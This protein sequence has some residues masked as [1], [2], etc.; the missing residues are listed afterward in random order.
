MI[1]KSMAF[2]ILISLIL[3]MQFASSQYQAQ[4]SLGQNLQKGVAQFTDAVWS[5]ADGFVTFFFG[6]GSV[7]L[8][9]Q[10]L[11][12]L[13]IV[14]TL[15]YVLT[16]RIPLFAEKKTTIWII[17][18]SVS[19]LATRFLTRSDFVSSVLLSYSVL[20]V[21]LTSVLPLVIYFFFV[22]SFKDNP[23][24]RKILWLFFIGVFM[25]LWW[26]RSY[27][28]GWGDLEWIYFFTGIFALIF[29]LFDGTIRRALINMEMSETGFTNRA[30][31]QADILKRMD[32]TRANVS[33]G[34]LS[35][36]AGNAIIGRL[37]RQLKALAKG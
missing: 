26:Y 11:L 24:L 37:H 35:E 23:I 32:E 12:I 13:L 27:D 33:K 14:F 8:Q 4:T 7:E 17:T 34:Y 21:V 18:I 9:F 5:F 22:H 29:L 19:L 36:G 6:P 28:P 10:R 15:V 3:L 1:K 30:Q 2:G 31:F 16:S 25:G 20:G